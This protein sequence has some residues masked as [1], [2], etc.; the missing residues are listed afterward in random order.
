MKILVTGGQSQF[1][2]ALKEI[3]GDI[4]LNP[5]K[6]EL[7]LE[8]I[9][10]V[11]S[12]TNNNPDI[13]YI[14]FNA[15]QNY[16]SSLNTTEEFTDES[17]VDGLHK[18]FMIQVVSTGILLHQYKSTLKKVIGLSTG[19]VNE[20]ETDSY[21]FGKELLTTTFSRL[22]HLE[23]FTS[24]QFVTIN[25]GP[26]NSDTEYKNHSHKLIQWIT[27]DYSVEKNVIHG[28]DDI[29]NL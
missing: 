25:P 26:M 19:M 21:V 16:Y 8:S 13:E 22:S 9:D 14:I 17:K 7:D 15:N 20:P 1:G 6:E 10:S 29:E 12:Y 27:K 4:I 3:H 11:M 28:I 23:E 18:L 24:V 5:G 2:R